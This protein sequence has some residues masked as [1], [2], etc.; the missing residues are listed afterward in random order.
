MADCEGQWAE[1]E[2]GWFHRATPSPVAATHA[3]SPTTKN[4]ASIAGPGPAAI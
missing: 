1:P 4:T 3:T 2:L